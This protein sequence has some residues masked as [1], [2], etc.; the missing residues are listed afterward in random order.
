MP[1]SQIYVSPEVQKEKEFKYYN[2]T[3]AYITMRDSYMVDAE[4][5][6]KQ[7][8]TIWFDD[9]VHWLRETVNPEPHELNID[10]LVLRKFAGKTFTVTTGLMRETLALCKKVT[11]HPGILA[12][13][14]LR[15]KRIFGEKASIDE[16]ASFKSKVKK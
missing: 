4:G 10:K 7:P 11:K 2:N 12:C 13:E 5:E 15:K 16:M 9:V 1:E 8:R 6:K 3:Y 14:Y